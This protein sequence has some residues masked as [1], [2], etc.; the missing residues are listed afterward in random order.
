[1]ASDANDC[2]TGFASEE[3][4]CKLIPAVLTSD[5]NTSEANLA[6]EANG[7]FKNSLSAEAQ[8]SQISTMMVW[9]PKEVKSEAAP[10]SPI[11]LNS[12]ATINLSNLEH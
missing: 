12:S 10:L 4:D 7:N 1:L 2:E 6:S 8:D 9:K 11:N 5:A 3:N